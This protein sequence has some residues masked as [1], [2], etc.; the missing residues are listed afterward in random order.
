[1][2]VFTPSLAVDYILEDFE[3]LNVFA[4]PGSST[5]MS[6]YD[7][8]NF[9]NG[10]ADDIKHA[11]HEGRLFWWTADTFR[12]RFFRPF[13]SLLHH[14][15]W[16]LFG[17]AIVPRKLH[18]LTWLFALLFV[19]SA[20]LRS[21]GQDSIAAL[22][23][24]II[25]VDDSFGMPMLWVASRN[26]LVAATFSFSALW[27]VVEGLRASRGGLWQLAGSL[28]LFAI[29][30]LA[31]EVSVVCG[32]YIFSALLCL[33]SEN[34]SFRV[35]AFIGF[36]IVLLAY[37]LTVGSL[38][39][40]T[41]DSGLYLDPRKN[42]PEWLD[43]FPGRFFI[44]LS[45]LFSNAPI[46]LISIVPGLEPVFVVLGVAL[47][48]LFIVASVR[49]VRVSEPAV[50]RRFTF[51]CLATA[52][53]TIP[54]TATFPNPRLLMVPGI[55]FSVVLVMLAK[56][57]ARG[58]HAWIFGHRE[59]ESQRASA[60]CNYVL[61]A[62]TLL[63]IFLHTVFALG[64]RFTE[65][66]VVKRLSDET[67]R[68]STG[69]SIR[70][71]AVRAAFYLRSPDIYSAL[72]ARHI[73]VAKGYRVPE[74]LV[75]L[76][77]NSLPLRISR[78]AADMFMME[79]LEGELMTS[80]GEILMRSAILGF[81]KGEEVETKEF[82]A[83]VETIRNGFPSKISFRFREDLESHSYQFLMWKD[84][85]YVEFKF[86]APGTSIELP[87]TTGILENL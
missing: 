26:A 58:M 87:A 78:V 74:M 12:I 23:L 38:G 62:T 8:F 9:S 29:G 67:L 54:A 1:M 21:L 5:F 68:V 13:S 65:A 11:I 33:R 3:Q 7:L 55:G 72:T 47:A 86:P 59:A 50:R 30:L 42:F 10:Q 83:R 4:K 48:V 49:F 46:A 35:Y 64:V 76:A 22:A 43:A 18:S 85:N 79:S 66:H 20:T 34:A 6:R 80:D 84:D 60:S 69:F 61:Y 45:C 2:I 53:S 56:H 81:R 28:S 17:D 52:L 16:L 36:G 39:F 25:S 27:L 32:A 31:G 71:K 57:Y 15:D 44:Q 14:V 63:F 37:F 82:T 40:G 73:R 51:W 75:P 41:S 19:V 77:C 70:S 24:L